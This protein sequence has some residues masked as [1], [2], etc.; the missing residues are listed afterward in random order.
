VDPA[1]KFLYFCGEASTY[2]GILSIDGTT[3]ALTPASESSVYTAATP[4]GMM[5]VSVPQQ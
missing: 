3:G 1:G 5:F 4:L 2:I